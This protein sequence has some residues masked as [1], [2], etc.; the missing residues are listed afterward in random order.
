MCSFLC[1]CWE[2]FAL[3]FLLSMLRKHPEDLTVPNTADLLRKVCVNEGSPEGW[4]DPSEFQEEQGGTTPGRI[5]KLAAYVPWKKMI[6]IRLGIPQV[7]SHNINKNSSQF[8]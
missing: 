4:Q 5:V 8:L 7:P 2:V 1:I 6:S 3:G